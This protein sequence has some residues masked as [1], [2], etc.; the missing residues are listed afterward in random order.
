MLSTRNCYPNDDYVDDVIQTLH[1]YKQHSQKGT[2]K[3]C[4]T[5]AEIFNKTISVRSYF[6]LLLTFKCTQLYWKGIPSS[7]SQRNSQ[8]KNFFSR[9]SF[10]SFLTRQLM[11][12]DWN[13]KWRNDYVQLRRKTDKNIFFIAEE[14]RAFT[15]SLRMIM[16]GWFLSNI[17]VNWVNLYHVK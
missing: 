17:K 13:F 15:I 4:S 10:P 3:F 16:R 5:F 14:L 7:I 11:A 2:Q 1:I 9:E 8:W 6:S 12:F